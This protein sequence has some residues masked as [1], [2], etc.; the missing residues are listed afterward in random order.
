[1]NSFLKENF[2]LGVPRSKSFTH[3]SFPEMQDT[4]VAV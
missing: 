3:G 1:M 4:Q 2:L